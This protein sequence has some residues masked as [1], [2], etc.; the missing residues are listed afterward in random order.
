MN[1]CDLLAY[2]AIGKRFF[3][4]E[5]WDAGVERVARLIQKWPDGLFGV[6][7]ADE[8]VGY[9][10]LWPLTADA[11]FGVE[12]GVIS[13]ERIDADLLPSSFMVPHSHWIC[14]TIAI[15]EPD[16]SVRRI[17]R[18]LLVNFM[19]ESTRRNRP[20]EIYSHAVTAAGRRFCLR[21]GF[22]FR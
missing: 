22:V 19:L 1:T 9:I 7:K 18:Q 21:N 15:D 13:D 16:K 20:C 5:D 3:P 4:N 8:I 17:I 10:A 2:K 11:A 6:W 12:S 14:T